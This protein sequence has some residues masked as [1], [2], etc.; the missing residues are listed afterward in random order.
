MTSKITLLHRF[1]EKFLKIFQAHGNSIASPL[2]QTPD[3]QPL[4]PVEASSKLTSKR[5]VPQR[6][7]VAIQSDDLHDSA[8]QWTVGTEK[9]VSPSLLT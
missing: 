7:L 8:V 9:C 2:P 5:I 4:S 6:R 3:N 1:I